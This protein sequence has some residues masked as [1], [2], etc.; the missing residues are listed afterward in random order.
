MKL[1]TLDKKL[2]HQD[3]VALWH[4]RLGHIS[5]K[6]ITRLI[7]SDI[8]KPLDIS[9]LGPCI[10]CAKGKQTS[11]RKY[12]ANRM[13]DVLELIHTY[14]CG[15]FPTATRNEHVYFISFID[16]YSRYGYIFLIKKILK[17]WTHLN[18]S[19]LKLSYNSTK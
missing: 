4:K 15:P 8:L 3:S 17:L 10:E 18:P 2:T 5:Q 14:I 9:D 12:T 7:Q 11:M 13:K 19:R 6:R 16:D 1:E